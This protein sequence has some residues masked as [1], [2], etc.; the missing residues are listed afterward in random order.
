MDL[1]LC[2]LITKGLF[3]LSE[4]VKSSVFRLTENAFLRGGMFFEAEFMLRAF[5]EGS[6]LSKMTFLALS[7]GESIPLK[8]SSL[9]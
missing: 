5:C 3:N 2:L 4:R 9:F 6:G 1:S 8:T 7:S